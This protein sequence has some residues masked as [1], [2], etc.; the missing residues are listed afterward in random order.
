M[1]MPGMPKKF[2]LVVMAVVVGAFAVSGCSSVRKKFIRTPKG[3]KAAD[4][5]IPVLEPVEY[6][7]TAE[8][9]QQVYQV[10]YSSLRAYFEDLWDTLGKSGSSEKREKY[11]LTEITTHF[12]AMAAQLS[13]PKKS[14]AAAVRARIAKVLD[15]CDKPR[16]MRRYDR[17]VADMRAVE[18][19]IHKT[20]KPG[21]VISAFAVTMK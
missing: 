20:F 8:T 2:I 19:D 14:E 16:A 1:T 15:E 4:A 18:R 17:M 3:P 21:V 13:E 11:I 6:A 7:K 12:D 5:F 9:P 10:H